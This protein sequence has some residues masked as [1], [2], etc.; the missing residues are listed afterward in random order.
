MEE[1]VMAKLTIVFGVVLV[2]IGGAGVWL[3]GAGFHPAIFGLVLILCG[4]LANTENAKR[5]MLWMH[6]AVTIGLLGFLVPGIMSVVALVKA[7]S[8]GVALAKPGMID[9]QL[10]VAGVCLVF[11]A[12]CVRSFI[13]AR[14]SRTA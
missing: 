3:I 8:A 7:H 10:I 11:V 12:L 5:R 2:L 6:I 1:S 14:R 13:A 9:E 4:V